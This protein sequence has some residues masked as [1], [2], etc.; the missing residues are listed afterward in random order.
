MATDPNVL[1]DLAHVRKVL[2]DAR[3]ALVDGGAWGHESLVDAAKRVRK[4]IDDLTAFLDA[5]KVPPAPTLLDRTRDF[6]HR[7]T[8]AV[9]KYRDRMGELPFI[10]DPREA[11]YVAGWLACLMFVVEGAVK[12][13][14]DPRD[15][16]GRAAA[17][18]AFR[19]WAAE[20][21]KKKGFPPEI[22]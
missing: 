9:N 10:I 16:T 22:P 5:C 3:A 14:E 6:Y 19:R 18:F 4:E 2:A 11:P 13:R 20:E 12:A 15:P 8:D 1:E 21:D 17:L 7:C